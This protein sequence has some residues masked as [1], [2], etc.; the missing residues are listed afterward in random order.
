MGADLVKK[1]NEEMV[2]HAHIWDALMI[3]APTGDEGRRQLDELKEAGEVGVARRDKSHN[4]F[5][6]KRTE[7]ESIGLTMNQWYT[8]RAD[9]IDDEKGA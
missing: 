8:S 4:A 3:F 7:G 2:R 9:Y 6:G 1:A 5:E